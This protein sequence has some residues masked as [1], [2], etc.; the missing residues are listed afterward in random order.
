MADMITLHIDGTTAEAPR[1]ASIFESAEVVG[2]RI[3]TSC[4]KNGKCRECMVE[5]EEGMECLTPRTEAERHLS[6][7]FRLSCRARIRP[8]ASGTIRCRT[9]RRGH[10]Q[11]AES[12]STRT[13]LAEID[14]AVTRAGDAVFMDGEP[15]GRWPGAIHGVAIDLGTTTVVL[16]L[17]DLESGEV[18]AVQSLEN[19]QRFGGSDV[20]A[21]IQYDTD[22]PGRLLQRTLLGYLT[23]AIEAFPCQPRSIFEILVV[24]NSTMRDLFF[25]LSVESIGQKPYRSLVEHEF[26]EGKRGTTALAVPAGKLRLPANPAAR[27]TSLPLI[28]G[29][30]GADAT[31]CLL[32]IGLAD[33]ERIVVLMDIGTNTEFAVGNRDELY[34][35]SCPAGPAFEGGNI[36][37]GMA[38]LDGAIESVAID[39]ADGSV[40]YGVIGDAEAEGICGSGMVDLLSELLQT[41]R[42]NELG[43][44]EDESERFVI[45][46]QRDLF[47]TEKDISELAQAKAANVSGGQIVLKQAAIEAH[48]IERFYLAGGFANHLDLEAAQG[49]GLVP[50]LPLEIVQPIGNAAIE[51]ATIALLSAARRGRVED[52]VRKAVH[53]ELETDETFFDHF[54]EGCQFKPVN[55]P[56]PSED[57]ATR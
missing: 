44:Y 3:P 9:L 15:I 48:E 1:G 42:M 18:V 52:L 11:I 45:D 41:G 57:T 30:V 47:L 32:A 34:V 55:V 13:S 54:V 17:V 23:H 7:D 38:G 33:E 51:G 22:H 26:R 5:V 4:L 8:G 35:A 27:V 39:R 36:A 2:V 43:R 6:G 10:L 20:M 31:A 37:C 50:S 56:R 24:G 28:S 12:G 40:S 14:P 29:H 16:R 21:R 25:G 53:V 49:I 19:P 46:S